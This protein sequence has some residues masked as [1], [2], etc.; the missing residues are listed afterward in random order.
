MHVTGFDYLMLCLF[1]I[2]RFT[3]AHNEGHRCV[4]VCLCDTFFTR[5]FSVIYE[6]P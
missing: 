3:V 2:V 4:W 1:V 6:L 5:Y